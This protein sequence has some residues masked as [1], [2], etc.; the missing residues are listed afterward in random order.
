MA[1]LCGYRSQGE[2]AG[3]TQ[4]QPS[5]VMAAGR[6]RP[7]VCPE[8]QT[9]VTTVTATDPDIPPRSRARPIA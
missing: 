5:P 2:A 6:Q 7:L 8:N 1:V 3:A 4:R 9:A